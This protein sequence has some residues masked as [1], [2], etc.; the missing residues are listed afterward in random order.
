MLE[1]ARKVNDYRAAVG[2]K[3]LKSLTWENKE[4]GENKSKDYPKRQSEFQSWAKRVG[5]RK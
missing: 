3:P 4:T 2:L 1:D 5:W